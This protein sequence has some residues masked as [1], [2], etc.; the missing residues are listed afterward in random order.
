MTNKLASDLE[1]SLRPH[2][3]TRYALEARCTLSTSDSEI[4]LPAGQH[5]ASFDFTQLR[6]LT[7]D[8]AEYGKALCEGLFADADVRTIFSQAL[9]HSETQ[10]GSLRLR[11]FIDANA[12]ELHAV[13]WELLHH[14]LSGEP[15]CTSERV[16]FSRYLS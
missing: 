16:L 8:S 11:L 5:L 14:P 3:A 4:S 9:T 15:L 1:L 10:N 2:D 12:S 7:L 13:R 6:R